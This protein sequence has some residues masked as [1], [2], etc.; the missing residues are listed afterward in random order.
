MTKFKIWL[1]TQVQF[2][3]TNNWGG[4]TFYVDG[5]KYKFEMDAAYFHNGFFAKW[6][7]HRPSNKRN[8]NPEAAFNFVNELVERRQAI[9]VEP[10]LNKPSKIQG[11]LFP[12]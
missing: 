10:A 2:G 1:E 5:V 4:I 8:Y 11:T 6:I 7:D 12:M 3:G 9:Q